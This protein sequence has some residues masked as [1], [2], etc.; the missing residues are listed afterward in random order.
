MAVST[1][2]TY[3]MGETW[4]IVDMVVLSSL[5]YLSLRVGEDWKNNYPLIAKW[6]AG[7]YQR[8]SVQITILIA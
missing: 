1:A 3:L 6:F 2:T 4:T 5:G 7:L 8:Q